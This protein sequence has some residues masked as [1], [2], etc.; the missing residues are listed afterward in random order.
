MQFFY[1]LQIITTRVCD[2]NNN[3]DKN[4]FFN[5]LKIVINFCKKIIIN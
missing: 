2:F 4:N 3:Y 1:R 5:N